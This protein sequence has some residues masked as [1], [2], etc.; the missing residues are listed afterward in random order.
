MKSSHLALIAATVLNSMAIYS[1]STARAF[2]V[3]ETALEWKLQDF[4]S[5]LSKMLPQPHSPVEFMKINYD[6]EIV[7]WLDGIDA[8]LENSSLKEFDGDFMFSLDDEGRVKALS[9]LDLRDPD[10]DHFREF[11]G[12]FALWKFP[13]PP[14]S[15]PKGTK[16]NLN[17][18]YLFIDRRFEDTLKKEEVVEDE[19]AITKSKDNEEL[20][21]QLNERDSLS[22][23]L[24]KPRNIEYPRVGEQII[25][26]TSQ[27]DPQ[28]EDLET[29]FQ[30]R[31]VKT[32]KKDMTILTS[33]IK[34][35]NGELASKDLLWNVKVDNHD[36][37]SNLMA[38]MTSGAIHMVSTVGLVGAA[39]TYGISI[40]SAILLGMVSGGI[41][42]W[43]KSPAF[44]LNSET[45]ITIKSKWRNK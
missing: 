14:E 19:F 35:P 38:S 7:S 1:P 26:R 25:F 10:V 29:I 18:K 13:A 41:K 4:E 3:S 21:K 31:I 20:I 28:A 42:E 45:P 24:I 30:G 34:L 27:G 9:I 37:A 23:Q 22:I 5:Y 15:I 44:N 8:Q 11:V 2:Y 40:G 33:K 32:G 16:F 17:A 43:D 12:E 6:D 36:L 39:E